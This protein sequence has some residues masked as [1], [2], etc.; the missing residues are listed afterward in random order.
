MKV[1][2]TVTAPH[3]QAILFVCSRKGENTSLLFIS[4]HQLDIINVTGMAMN[5]LGLTHHDNWLE[6]FRTSPYVEITVS[7][8]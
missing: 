2:K 7:R 8:S 5:I 1:D 3:N 6:K 4:L